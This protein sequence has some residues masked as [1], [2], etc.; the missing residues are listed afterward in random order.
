MKHMRGDV[1]RRAVGAIQGD[2]QTAQIK[3]V[4]ERAFAE[5]DITTC[6]IGNPARASQLGRRYAANRRI[7][8][9]FNLR[10]KRIVQLG[11]V[12]REKFDAVIVE[13]IVRGGNNDAGL[14]AQ[15][16]RQIRHGGRRHGSDQ[17]NIDARCRKTRFQRRFQHIAGNPRI[18]ADQ[19]GR[20]LTIGGLFTQNVAGGV[21]QAH[22]KIRGNR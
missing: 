4:G 14:Q 11:S 20:P 5:L 13:R 12:R 21:P 18:L 2:F 7:D 8:T 15:R 16:P 6:R 10:F 22:H 19:Y 3:I 17:A 9:R 1:I